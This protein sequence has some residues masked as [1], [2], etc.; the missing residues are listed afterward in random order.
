MTENDYVYCVLQTG[1]TC[2]GVEICGECVTQTMEI[3]KEELE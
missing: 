2:S 1:H 3:E